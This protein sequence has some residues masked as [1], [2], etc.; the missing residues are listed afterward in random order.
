MSGDGPKRFAH[1]ILVVDD[2][3]TILKTAA[4][5]LASGGYEVHTARDG[6]EALT[7]LRGSLPD[8]LISDLSMPNMSGFE[9]LSVVRRRFPHLPVIAISGQYNG[10]A[11]AGLIAD[12]FFSKGHYNPEEL[13]ATISELLE[14][15]PI[16]P[17]IAK[18][19]KAP[20]WI[21]K[22]STGYF[23]VTCPNCLRSFSVE[24][25]NGREYRETECVYCNSTVCYLAD[26]SAM[27]RKA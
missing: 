7:V 21:P 20:V 16:R 22:N 12:A 14:Q 26:L 17:N 2:E 11:P 6:F 18:P 8:I 5:V 19:D 1:R 3:P 13:F 27:K 23:V 9:L 4:L 25:K 10:T 15:A 24:D